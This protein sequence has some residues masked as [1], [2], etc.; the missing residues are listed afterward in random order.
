M[1]KIEFLRI[2]K[3]GNSYHSKNQKEKTMGPVFMHDY[4]LNFVFFLKKE[5]AV[6][7]WKNIVKTMVKIYKWLLNK[8]H[9]NEK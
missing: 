6:F 5:N 7:R 2:L 4:I 3:K 9:F 1:H 8:F